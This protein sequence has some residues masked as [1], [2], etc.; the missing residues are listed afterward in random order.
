MKILIGEL[1][2]LIKNQ[3]VF[4]GNTISHQSMRDLVDA[5]IATTNE[6]GDYISTDRGN[7]VWN[8]FT[9]RTIEVKET[10]HFT[11]DK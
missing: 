4:A 3:P 2:N 8:Q 1:V 10:H 7:W 6:D 9:C 11:F 5:G